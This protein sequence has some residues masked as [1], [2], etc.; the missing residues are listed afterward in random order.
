MSR[1]RGRAYSQDLRDRVLATECEPIRLVAERFCV[2]PSYVSKVRSRRLLAGATTPGPQHNNVPPRLALLYDALR[3]RVAE[4]VDAT[5]LELR[6]WVAREHGV[7]IGHSV[8]WKTVRPYVR[9]WS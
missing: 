6:T 1:Q 9:L 8:M 3:A 4:Q 7:A 5:I 2:S